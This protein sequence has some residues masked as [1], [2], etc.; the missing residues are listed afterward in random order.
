MENSCLKF[1]IYVPRD[2]RVYFR[3]F[4]RIQPQESGEAIVSTAI[5]S[6][7]GRTGALFPETRFCMDLIKLVNGHASDTLFLN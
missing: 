2:V 7:N 5:C 3:C 6:G 4:R 1:G